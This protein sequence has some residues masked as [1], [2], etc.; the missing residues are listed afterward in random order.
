MTS[1]QTNCTLKHFQGTMLSTFDLQ[2]VSAER[3]AAVLV[4]CDKFSLDP[5]DKLNTHPKFEDLSKPVAV[6]LRCS[7]E[8]QPNK[9][10]R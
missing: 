1:I 10:S 5:S 8:N 7:D 2:R 4:L 6:F 9:P 3:A